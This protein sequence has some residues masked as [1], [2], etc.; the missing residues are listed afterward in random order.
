VETNHRHFLAFRVEH[1]WAA[2]AC[3]AT[4]SL[5]AISWRAKRG[6][7]LALMDPV[8]DG[9][10]VKKTRN[11]VAVA[12]LGSLA[13]GCTV[14]GSASVQTP[15]PP[16]AEVQVQVAAPPPA[17]PPP[18]VEAPP[19]APPQVEI[20]VEGEPPPPP[21]AEHEVVPASPGAEFFWVP[22]YH[23]WDG[24][25][26]VWVRGRYERRP[27]QN[28][29]WKTA[30]WEPRAHGHVWVEGNWEGEATVAPAPAPAPVAAA[31]PAAAH[32]YYLHA[33][34]DL[35]NARANLER[36][37]GDK[38][39]KWDE[40]DGVAAIDRAIK[41]IKGAA[42]DDGKNLDD[43]PAVDAR[44][45]RDGRL[46]KALVA[47]QTA[48]GDIDKEEDNAFA[49]GLRNRASHDIDEAIRFT[50]AG[51]Q[52]AAAEGKTVVTAAPVPPP[53]PAAA[54]PYY[55][56]ALADLRN[57]RANLER[58]GGDKQ[59][60]W[61]EH[62][63]V[64]A[65]DR[66]IK[67]IKEAALDDGKNI[68]DHPPV[69]AR[70]PRDGRL[71]KALAALQTARGDIDKEEDN[72]FANGL[73]NRASHDI[74]EAI[75]ATQAGEQAAAAEGK[76]GAAPPAA[77]AAPVAAAHPH[78]LQALADLRNARANLE[79]KGGDKQMKWDEK[80]AIVAIDRAIKDIKEAA[81]DDGKNIED[82]A[83]VD[84]HEPRGGRLHKALSALQTARGDID[85]EE[86]NGFANGLRARASHDID[87][88][89][90]ATEAGVQAAASAS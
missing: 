71:H 64:A 60:K 10:I 22:G 67:D 65:I 87:E 16:Q 83:T 88:A 79:R 6:A 12:L 46:H 70:E 5:R 61:D 15:P 39:M 13:V 66:A 28:A 68:E 45:P 38:Q 73:R 86:D 37:G 42:L 89:I 25:H 82:H 23:R 8:E 74:D 72:A 81:L 50:E 35:R 49:S 58:K 90:H 2:E 77:P 54:H 44:E 17:P 19:P 43:H 27:H 56:H 57:A 34:S 29:R 36:K 20:V 55:L 76:V 80:D 59:M 9:E 62:D 11:V 4:R 85:K 30:H 7:L 40:H 75:H 14:H 78:Y 53:S 32:P 48:R 52:A 1:R 41:D 24:H 3:L 33:L 63:G 31:T 21:A 69:D 26:Y 51:V 47:L 18:V 84:A